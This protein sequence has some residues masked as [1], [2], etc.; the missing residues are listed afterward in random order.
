[1]AFLF[2]KYAHTSIF[3]NLSQQ[4][5]FHLFNRNQLIKINANDGIY[6]FISRWY[7][8]MLKK[9]DKFLTNVFFM[10]HFN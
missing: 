2:V 4:F 6:E 10:Y 8:T 3:Y 9:I 1:M 7:A 5:F